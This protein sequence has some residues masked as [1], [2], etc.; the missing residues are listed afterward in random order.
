MKAGSGTLH[1]VLVEA[2]LLRPEWV[3]PNEYRMV[4]RFDDGRLVETLVPV[5]LMR[6]PTSFL[7]PPAWHKGKPPE[8]DFRRAEGPEFV[9]E[10]RWA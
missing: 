1:S 7:M 2:G 4:H 8:V 6:V 5:C 10:T 3:N 9:R